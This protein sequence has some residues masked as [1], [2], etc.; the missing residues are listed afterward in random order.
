ML[1]HIKMTV[2]K[3]LGLVYEVGTDIGRVEA[4]GNVVTGMAV[5]CDPP[6]V[7][8][9]EPP[10]VIVEESKTAGTA[11]PKTAIGGGLEN[12]ASLA[13]GSKPAEKPKL[14]ARQLKAKGRPAGA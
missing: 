3:Q 4:E 10:T 6:K 7:T 13:M 9:V 14:P 1:T 5:W 8:V 12:K 2:G 11:T